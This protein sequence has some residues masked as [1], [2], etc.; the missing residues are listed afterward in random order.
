M[1]SFKKLKK[2]YKQPRNWFFT[3]LALPIACIAYFFCRDRVYNCFMDISTSSGP[4]FF[5]VKILTVI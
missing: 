5:Q 4:F 2:F 1:N 3:I